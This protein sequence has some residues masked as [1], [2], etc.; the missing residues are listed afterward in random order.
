MEVGVWTLLLVVLQYFLF[1]YLF[2]AFFFFSPIRMLVCRLL[3]SL[4][5][6]SLLSYFMVV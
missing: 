6:S 2:L 3:V 1:G 4:L 5:N